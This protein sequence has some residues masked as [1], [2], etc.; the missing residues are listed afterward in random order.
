MEAKAQFTLFVDLPAAF[1]CSME[2]EEGCRCFMELSVV[3]MEPEEAF[4]LSIELSPL[5]WSLKKLFYGAFSRLMEPD[6][7]FN[8]TMELLERA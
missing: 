5:F 3:L 6:E 4:R 7:A 1:L 2:L 8:C